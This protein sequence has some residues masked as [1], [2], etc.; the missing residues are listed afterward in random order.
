MRRSLCRR[1]T[2][3]GIGPTLQN[4]GAPYPGRL[5]DP[6]L[7]LHDANSV[8][9]SNNDWKQNQ[10]EVEATGIPPTHDKES[11]IVRTLAPGQYTVILR[12][13]NNTT[14][15]AVVEIYDLDP[16]GASELANLSS[17]GLVGIGDNILIGG[18]FTGPQ[19]ASHTKVVV[20]AIGPSVKNQLPNALDDP[21]LELRDS[22]GVVK[23][24]NDNW[25]ETQEAEIQATG[26]AP[27]NDAESALVETLTPGNYTAIV[28]GKN[29]TGIGVVEI[30]HIP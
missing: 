14:G 28:R 13:N 10:A 21:T 2:L 9:A 29:Q 1:R 27:T 7:E 6:T 4:N 20:R 22:F 15:T 8:I 23:A 30:Y 3:R 17:R 24:A 19:T 5:E 12:G 11:A 16:A 26:L 18:F 25:K